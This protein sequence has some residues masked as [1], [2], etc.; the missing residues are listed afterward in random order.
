MYR[1][2]VDV[3]WQFILVLNPKETV[4]IPM[5]WKFVFVSYCP[6]P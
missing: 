3:A 4:K 5:M 6:V 2:C 1:G